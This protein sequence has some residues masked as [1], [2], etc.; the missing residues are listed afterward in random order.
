[1]AYSIRAPVS[2]S[3]S[4]LPPLAATA[5]MRESSLSAL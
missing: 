5:L 4:A 3:M 2:A 1:L